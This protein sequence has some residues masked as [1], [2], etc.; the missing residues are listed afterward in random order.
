MAVPD[1]YAFMKPVLKCLSMDDRTPVRNLAGLVCGRMQFSSNELS[2]K[3]PSGNSKVDSRIYTALEYLSHAELVER[4]ERGHYKLSPEG[5]AVL[6][7]NLD[8]INLRFLK[9]Y[10]S[11][12]NWWSRTKPEPTP[13]ADSPSRDSQS[14]NGQATEA[15]SESSEEEIEAKLARQELMPQEL[16]HRPKRVVETAIDSLRQ[17]IRDITQLLEEEV[18]KVLR[19]LPP[20]FCEKAVV[21]LLVAMGYGGSNAESGITTGGTGDQ[22]IDGVIQEDPLGLSKVY[23]QVKRYAAKNRVGS[24][25]LRNFV[26]AID[27]A[28]TMKGVFVTTSSFTDGARTVARQTSKNVIL[29][30]GKELASLMVQHGVGVRMASIYKVK[31][32]D[33]DYFSVE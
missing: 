4:P 26:G 2:E 13:L 19:E 23:I 30:D 11:F 3:F 12:A 31:R 20:A 33:R 24:S 18:L 17:A 5:Q 9:Q 8:E 27:Q 6:D 7:R 21:D 28:G 14:H 15:L 10:P 29:I 32:I 25:D 1:L 22:G 16:K